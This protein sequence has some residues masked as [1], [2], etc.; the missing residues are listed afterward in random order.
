MPDGEVE[1]V[2][3]LLVDTPEVHGR[4]EC[5][6]PEASEFVAGLL[7]E[8]TAVRLER[9]TTNRD[10]F[11][12]LLRYVHLPDGSMLNERLAAEGYAEF[13]L[14]DGKNVRHAG[15]IE[16]AEARARAN[17]AGLW[18]A[19]GKLSPLGDECDPAY[20]NLCVPRPPPD[21]DCADMLP[22]LREAGL[23]HLEVA[24]GG[25][26]PHRLDRDGDGRAC[27]VE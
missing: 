19:C 25:G 22:M 23:P 2:R 27:V 12:R 10:A 1:K 13:N 17:R 5:Y 8:G 15:R 21:L 6:G 18:S 14:Y 9:D 7:P 20:L 11:G 4:V 26:D 24:P 16:A 3:L